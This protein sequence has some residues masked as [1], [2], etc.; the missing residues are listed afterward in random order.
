MYRDAGGSAVAWKQSQRRQPRVDPSDRGGIGFSSHQHIPMTSAEA[1]AAS[2]PSSA[3]GGPKQ[4]GIGRT[5]PPPPPFPQAAQAPPPP[6]V[7]QQF[8]PATS[9]GTGTSL[10]GFRSGGV[11]GGATSSFSASASTSAPPPSSSNRGGIGSSYGRGGIGSGG[12]GY[13]HANKAIPAPPAAPAAVSS[14]GSQPASSSSSDPAPGERK[15]KSRW[16]DPEPH[17]QRV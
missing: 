13:G 7:S 3:Y 9:G 15:R 12:Y 5:P 6:R 1:A 17:R 10:P 4:T 11:L 14:S 2:G 8:V 16:G